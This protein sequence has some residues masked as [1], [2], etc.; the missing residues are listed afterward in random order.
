MEALLADDESV[1]D[2][3]LAPIIHE[4]AEGMG[5]G[6]SGEVPDEGGPFHYVLGRPVPGEDGLV[7]VPGEGLER[8]TV[9][10]M[11]LHTHTLKVGEHLAV[12]GFPFPGET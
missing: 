10:D 8:G 2:H 7:L 5:P 3:L 9:Q 6:D 1:L 11:D 12:G 4:D